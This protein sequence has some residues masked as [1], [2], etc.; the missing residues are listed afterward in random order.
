MIIFVIILDGASVIFPGLNQVSSDVSVSGL[1]F[2]VM[3]PGRT[4]VSTDV[5]FQGQVQVFW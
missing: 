5:K 4:Q 2:S 3:F 1:V